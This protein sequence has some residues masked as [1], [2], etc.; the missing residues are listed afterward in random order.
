M[1]RHQ[2]RVKLLASPSTLTQFRKCTLLKCS[3]GTAW[4]ARVGCS[5]RVVCCQLLRLKANPLVILAFMIQFRSRWHRIV[6]RFHRPSHTEEQGPA[7]KVASERSRGNARG[8]EQQSQDDS[9][10]PDAR[11]RH[12]REQPRGVHRELVAEEGRREGW[13]D[14]ESVRGANVKPR[15]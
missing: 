7:F 13:M 6:T 5:R 2:A 1:H 15:S 3:W 4:D 9:P 12:P 11:S 14:R 8:E 10:N